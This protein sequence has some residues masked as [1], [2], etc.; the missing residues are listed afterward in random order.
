[1]HLHTMYHTLLVL[2]LDV[3][4]YAVACMCC[5]VCVIFWD[6]SVNSLSRM[7]GTWLMVGRQALLGLVSFVD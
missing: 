7:E 3:C 2:V 6:W 5:C 1:M 4:V